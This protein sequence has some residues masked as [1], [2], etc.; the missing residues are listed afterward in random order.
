MKGN[1][2]ILSFGAGLIGGA[3]EIDAIPSDEAP[4][5]L[6]N[7]R[8]SSQSFQPTLPSHVTCELSAKPRSRGSNARSGLRHSSIRNLR[9][10]SSCNSGFER[11]AFHAQ[12]VRSSGVFSTLRP[13]PLGYRLCVDGSE[14]HL[15][16][17][18]AW[19]RL[20]DAFHGS[21]RVELR[22]D[23]MHR[24]RVPRIMGVLSKISGSSTTIFSAAIS[25]RS[26]RST[27][28]Q[29]SAK[30]TVRKRPSLE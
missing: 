26:R 7:E 2:R 16:L 11:A 23:R 9:T 21:T 1:I 14:L 27:F 30:R 17:S 29:R 20:Q 4:V 13:A 8:F 28:C 19:I 24:P 5:L 6:Q 18:Q 22:S 12:D 15:R 3:P 10:T 25:V